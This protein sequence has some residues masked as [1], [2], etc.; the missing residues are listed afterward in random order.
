MTFTKIEKPRAGFR[1]TPV[2]GTKISSHD[3]V[4]S[5]YIGQDVAM[6]MG[7]N[8]ET[9]YDLMVG[10]GEDAGLACLQM[11]KNG[12]YKI[13]RDKK[14]SVTIRA[15][16]NSAFK[17]GKPNISSTQTQY[18]IEDG[19]LIVSIPMELR[20]F[21]KTPEPAVAPLPDGHTLN[22]TNPMR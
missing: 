19:R 12:N 6:K 16:L 17:K 5:L 20:P 1:G 8:H 9:R 21:L 14:T 15:S 2:M 3:R 13:Y 10:S 7:I 11:N 4:V 18:R 22:S